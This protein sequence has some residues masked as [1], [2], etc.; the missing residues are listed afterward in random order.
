MLIPYVCKADP[1]LLFKANPYYYAPQSKCLLGYEILVLHASRGGCL[2]VM[3]HEAETYFSCPSTYILSLH[4]MDPYDL[5]FLREGSSLSCSMRRIL[6]NM[7]HEVYPYSSR[8]EADPVLMPSE[9]DAYLLRSE[10]NDYFLW[11]MRRMLGS[12]SPQVEP[13]FCKANIYLSCL[14]RQTLI[15]YVRKTIFAYY[16][17]WSDN[18]FV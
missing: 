7:F 11:T 17:P 18:H 1:Y 14:A 9:A 12:Y 8:T 3:L 2:F 15:T 6:C 5:H 13:L 16:A 10:G 4:K